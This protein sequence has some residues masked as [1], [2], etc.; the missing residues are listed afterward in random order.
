[1]IKTIT[2]QS[3]EL[4]FNNFRNEYGERVELNETTE[5][6]H[7]RF[8]PVGVATKVPLQEIEDTPSTTTTTMSWELT[9]GENLIKHSVWLMFVNVRTNA[10]M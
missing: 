2:R 10:K 3:E 8:K 7:P 1:M 5:A 6:T 4:H 9:Q